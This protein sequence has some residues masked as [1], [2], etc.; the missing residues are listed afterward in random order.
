MPNEIKAMYIISLGLKYDLSKWVSTPVSIVAYKSF[1]INCQ[2]L[3]DFC[4][5][6]G[7]KIPVSNIWAPVNYG[8]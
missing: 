2:P 1:I 7:V 5:I 3:Y 6:S 4:V 8:E